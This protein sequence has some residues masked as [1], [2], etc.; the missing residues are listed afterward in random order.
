[1]E[2]KTKRVNS[3]VKVRNQRSKRNSDSEEASS[4]SSE[5]EE[6][7]N[8]ST[9]Q[10]RTIGDYR[11]AH[12]RRPRENTGLDLITL[13]A[14]EAETGKISFLYDT[15]VTI[16]LVKMKTLRANTIVHE[17]KTRLIGIS[18]HAIEPIGIVNI[19]ISLR[20]GT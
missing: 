19:T 9:K 10:E 14:R 12:I 1:M 16:T 18:G 15:G 5:D 20:D 2:N 7:N 8:T 17:N 3:S 6:K 13:P 4:T 11:I